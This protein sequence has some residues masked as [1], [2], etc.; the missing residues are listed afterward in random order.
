MNSIIKI[1]IAVALISSACSESFSQRAARKDYKAMLGDW[2]EGRLYVDAKTVLKGQLRFNNFENIVSLK[3]GDETKA[4][5]AQNI[6]RF[7]FDD[8]SSKRH[9]I[10]AALKDDESAQQYFFEVLMEC[11]HLAL[12]RHEKSESS[13]VTKGSPI[14]GIQNY[15]AVV[16]YSEYYI[17]NATGSRDLYMVITETNTSGWL[18]TE[19]KKKS[20]VDKHLFRKYMKDV[21]PQVKAWAKG[22]GYSFKDEDD[23]IRILEFYKTLER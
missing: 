12:L 10:S 2:H 18:F 1:L 15:D 6:Q 8:G 3:M 4:F 17:F 7:D 13:H 16:R 14:T 11:K 20:I 9:F 19:S 22:L 5:S 23:L 21:Y